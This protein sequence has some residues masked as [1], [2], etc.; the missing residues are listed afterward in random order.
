MEDQLA[1]STCKTP[2]ISFVLGL[3]LGSARLL[4]LHPSRLEELQSACQVL[5][6]RPYPT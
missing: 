2:R 6:P 4:S 3:G 1:R 5:L